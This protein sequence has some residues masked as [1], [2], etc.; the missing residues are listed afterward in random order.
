[1]TR[2]A[3][4]YPA[5][6]REKI[7][8]L[9]REGA[10]PRDLAAKFAPSLASIRNWIEEERTGIPAETA[11]RSRRLQKE[12]QMASAS[13]GQAE[14]LVSELNVTIR[15]LREENAFLEKMVAWLMVRMQ[16]GAAR[17]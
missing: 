9:A 1:M 3:N 4:Q 15:I 13:A 12:K 8:K 6:L 14:G 5:A 11:K 10:E 16:K 17:G 7:L 2:P